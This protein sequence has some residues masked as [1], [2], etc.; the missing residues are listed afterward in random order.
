FHSAG[1]PQTTPIADMTTPGLARVLAVK[2]IGA[3]RLDELTRDTDLD[4]FVL[5][6]WGAATWG[7]G[8]QAAYAAA[9]AY[10]DA[11][12]EPRR[13]R[14]QAA[15]SAAWGAWAGGGMTPPEGAIELRRRGLGQM[16]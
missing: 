14:G 1:V 13:A 7:S 5:F 15:T 8:Q 9:N 2:T 4:A 3:A 16:D 6:S 12:A 10:L 11:L